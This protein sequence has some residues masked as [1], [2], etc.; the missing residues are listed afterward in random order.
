ME[1]QHKLSLF[2]VERRY[3]I[4]DR[5]QTLR[6]QR[7]WTL[8]K[9]SEAT[10][11]DPKVISRHQNGELCSLESLVKYALA[12]GCSLEDLMPPELACQITGNTEEEQ[13][14][15]LMLLRLTKPQRD[16]IF[17]MISALAEKSA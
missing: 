10:G 11:I 17:G 14:Y 3:W 6:E 15:W 4:G 16:I 13:K 5:I 9:L 2:T 7:G 12:F 1:Q 8:E